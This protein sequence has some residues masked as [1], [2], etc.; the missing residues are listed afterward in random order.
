MVNNSDLKAMIMSC[1]AEM[2]TKADTNNVTSQIRKMV[3][4]STEAQPK[5]TTNLK[6][7]IKH[8]I[9]LDVKK[10]SKEVTKRKIITIQQESGGYNE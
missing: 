8:K 7:I 9:S 2:K 3:L 1:L 10:V 6:C 4:S 5:T